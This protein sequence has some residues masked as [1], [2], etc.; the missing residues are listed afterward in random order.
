MC[1]INAIVSSDLSKSTNIIN[2][3]NAIIH[4]GPDSQGFIN[5]SNFSIGHVRLSIKV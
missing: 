1:G 5:K 3:N 4:R 2:M